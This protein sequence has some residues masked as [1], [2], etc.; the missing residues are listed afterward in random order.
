MT[1]SPTFALTSEEKALLASLTFDYDDLRDRDP[2]ANGEAAL[3]LT[4][5]L[6]ERR[7][8]P[9]HRWRVFS[10]P[11]FNPGGY[12][13]SNQQIFERNGCSGEAICRNPHFLPYLDY[14]LH[15]ADLP[16]GFKS[17]FGE[18]VA[19]AAPITS[20]DL[21]PLGKLARQ[22][23]RDHGLTGTQARDEV[24]RLALD[25]GLGAWQAAFVRTAV[26]R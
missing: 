3:A 26:S 7:A 15:G 13:R 11:D 10:D 17:A 1:R 14:F 25:T 20:G 12:G 4:R 21:A 6:L 24:F 2:N 9:D 8:I 16:D 18:A 19:R 22:L 23:V 5:S